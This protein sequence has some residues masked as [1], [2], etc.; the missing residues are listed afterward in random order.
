MG[1]YQNRNQRF[2]FQMRLTEERDQQVAELTVQML[3]FDSIPIR[4][5]IIFILIGLRLAVRIL[6]HQF[7]NHI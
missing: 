2:Y 3:G 4:L 7:F 5:H 6:R 1:N